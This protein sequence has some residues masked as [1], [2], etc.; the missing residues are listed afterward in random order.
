MLLAGRSAQASLVA[1]PPFVGSMA[2]KAKDKWERVGPEGGTDPGDRLMVFTFGQVRNEKVSMTVPFAELSLQVRTWN[3]PA[4]VMYFMP[5]KGLYFSPYIS[6]R[7]TLSPEMAS[8][9]ILNC[10]LIV[11]FSSGL[12]APA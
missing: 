2:P 4:L 8:C 7:F 11:G 3:F 10:R 9:W 5:L 12:E 1:L 6:R